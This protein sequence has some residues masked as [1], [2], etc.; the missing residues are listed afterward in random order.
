[1]SLRQV[2]LAYHD[3]LEKLDQLEKRHDKKFRAVF[4]AL[5]QL[6]QEHEKAP[7]GFER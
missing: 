5:R 3:V 1:M 2:A 6:L 7:I 4:D